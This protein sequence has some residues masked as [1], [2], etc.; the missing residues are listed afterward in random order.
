MYSLSQIKRGLEWTRESPKEPLRELNRIYYTYRTEPDYNRS[1]VD[2]LSEAWDTLIIL[3]ACR[4]DLFR[5]RHTLEGDLE[6]RISRGSHTSEFLRGNFTGRT[7]HDTV[8]TTASPMYRRFEASIG[9]SFHNVID[10]W[11]SDQWDDDVGTVLPQEMT[12]AALR[13]HDQYPEKRHIVHFMQPHYPF[14][15]SDIDD[16]ER[17]FG[18]GDGEA[19]FWRKRFRGQIDTDRSAVWDAYRANFDRVIPAV[20]RLVGSIDGRVVVTADHGNLIGERVG[21]FPI[22]EW[23]HPRGIHADPLVRVPW[24]VCQTGPRRTVCESAPVDQ[25]IDDDDDTVSDRL[26]ALGYV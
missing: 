5:D 21:P 1:G 20:D 6:Q 2:V 12:D 9:A 14:I 23:G 7:I 4:F 17:T 10:V 25:D 3:D 22:A 15:S 8:Y 11:D 18:G 26:S 19:D 16:Q 13:S 24:F